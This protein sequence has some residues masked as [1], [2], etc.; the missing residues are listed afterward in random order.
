MK[1][2]TRASTPHRFAP[3]PSLAR[4]K[5]RA[6]QRCAVWSCGADLLG[7]QPLAARVRPSIRAC[8]AH[9][10]RDEELVLLLGKPDLTPLQTL[11][12]HAAA[13]CC[14]LTTFIPP[15]V[16]SCTCTADQHLLGRTSSVA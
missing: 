5:K 7:S 16:L 12:L 4:R 1:R 9:A 14:H 6:G 3:T 11:H 2:I 15:C 8:L 10:G 13:C